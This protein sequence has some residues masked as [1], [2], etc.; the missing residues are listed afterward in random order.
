MVNYNGALLDEKSNLFQLDN[1]GFRFGDVVFEKI[2]AVNGKLVFWEEHYFRLM[3]S[4]RILRMEI[5]MEFTME[6][7]ESEIL[8]ALDSNELLHKPAL[9]TI[10]VFRNSGLDILPKTQEVSY[11]MEVKPL[12]NPF[13]MMDDKDY[14]VE[15]F[16][17]YF[18]NRDMLTI[19]NTNNRMVE[20]I[21][22]VFA[23]ENGYS[24]CLLLN[25]GK[26]VVGAVSGSI[27]LV[28]DKKIKTPASSEGAKNTVLKKK[29]MEIIQSLDDYEMEDG[30]ISPFE[31]QKADELFIVNISKGIR[32]IT[33][34][35]K[36]SYNAIVAKNLLGKLNAI[37][38]LTS[39]K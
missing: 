18:I 13:Y 30:T 25:T 36:K 11:V 27:F 15:L 6:H 35:R 5:P 17:D 3:A 29:L 19:L 31:L 24:D 8:K 33:K 37:A 39:L 20:V 12:S 32:P 4:M 34:Y 10:S 28:K 1:R 16:K 14:E 26:Q 9:V 38:R 22:S 7:L 2:R 23:K 21:A